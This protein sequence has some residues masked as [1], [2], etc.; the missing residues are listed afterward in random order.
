MI[1]DQFAYIFGGYT[2]KKGEYFND[3]YRFDTSNNM[4]DVV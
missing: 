2:D 4:W 3:L 1:Q